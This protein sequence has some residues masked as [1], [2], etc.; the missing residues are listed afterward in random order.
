MLILLRGMRLNKF[1]L[2]SDS[3]L[4]GKDG[5]FEMALSLVM[6]L[7]AVVVRFRAPLIFK[8]RKSVLPKPSGKG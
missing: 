4:V 7:Y 5:C 6:A 2:D 8:Q 1:E 3:S